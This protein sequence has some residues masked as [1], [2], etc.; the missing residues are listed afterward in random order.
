M[1]SSQVTQAPTMSKRSLSERDDN[2]T[3]PISSNPSKKQRVDLASKSNIAEYFNHNFLSE[4][5]L[6]YEEDVKLHPYYLKYWQFYIN[7]KQEEI[8]DIEAVQQKQTRHK[9]PG[10]TP[11][12]IDVDDDHPI[13][14]TKS[15]RDQYESDRVRLINIK[16]LLYER[17]LKHLPGSY[18]LWYQYLK[19]RN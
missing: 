19:P 3:Q 8:D 13:L 9:K 2:T 11:T 18:K 5:D 16:F 14:W 7:S 10:A 12:D 1:W 17:A 15:V 4:R 6:Q